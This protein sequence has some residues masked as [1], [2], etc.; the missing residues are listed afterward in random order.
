[1]ISI[2]I[3]TF[4]EGPSLK[5]LLKILSEQTIRHEVIL[6][7]SE[8][9]DNTSALAEE[10]GCIIEQCIPFTYGKAL[11]IG[12]ERAKF[13]Y[14]CNLSAHCFPTDENFL[15]TMV[16]N[17]DNNR[18]AG[19]YSKQLAPDK[20]NILD[21]RNLAIVFRDEKLY[22]TKDSFFNNASSMIR[23]DIWKYVKFDEEIEA[24]E[25]IQWSK[26]VQA[27]NYIIVYEPDAA[28][29]HHHDEDN[30]RTIKRYEAEWSSLEQ[31]AKNTRTV[32][33]RDD[34]L[35]E[36]KVLAII[37]AKGD[38][39]RLPKK[40]LQLIN[41]KSLVEHAI[42]YAKECKYVNDIVVSTEDNKIMDLA[43]KN[44][45]KGMIRDKY[46]CGDTEVVDVYINVVNSLREKYDYVVGLQ[47]DHPDK[48]HSL[49][50]CLEYMVENYYD[51]LIT[52]TPDS[53][54]NG[55]VRIFKHDHLLAGHVS[56]RI[57]CIKDTATDIHYQ[58]DLDYV[59]E[60]LK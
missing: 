51:D 30:E 59:T 25:D 19:V 58:K 45:V 34:I 52:V 27:M 55:S 5:K 8:S 32:F 28:V 33:V 2:V 10:Y 6:V 53:E 13:K 47:P 17:F 3:R 29:Y 18:V 44:G 42:A 9:T 24:W 20:A 11:N 39:K 38:S 1:M 60:K 4:N 23:K 7:D 21:K 40:N 16:D 46:L 26:E 41:G 22:Q 48:S 31:I 54:R 36:I 14:I 49:D 37:P 43:I 57:G 56:K 35:D 50:Y 12:V 15:K